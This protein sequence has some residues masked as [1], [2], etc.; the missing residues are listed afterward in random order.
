MNVLTQR[1]GREGKKNKTEILRSL[2]PEK[3]V[4]KECDAKIKG[5]WDWEVPRGEVIKPHG[6]PSPVPKGHT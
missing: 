3:I 2:S 5:D 4:G 6:N 1:R